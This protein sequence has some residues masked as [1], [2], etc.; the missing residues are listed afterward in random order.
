MAKNCACS[1]A[2]CACSITQGTGVSVTGTGTAADPFVISAS[3]STLQ[4]AAGIAVSD[5]TTI[6]FGKH[7]TGTIS[8]PVI[9]T[10]QVV[11]RSPNNTRWTLTVA[12]DG[13]IGAVAA[14]AHPTVS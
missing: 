7:G 9:I 14:G 1:G 12:D 13:T 8:D 3:I 11:I 10:G 6:E 5:S 4:I 2:S